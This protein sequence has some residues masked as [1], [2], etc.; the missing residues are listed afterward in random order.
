MIVLYILGGYI[1]IC[2]LWMFVICPIYFHIHRDE[3]MGSG[4]IGFWLLP[5]FPIIMLV[6]QISGII[7]QYF[8]KHQPFFMSGQY[9]C[10]KCSVKLTKD[11]EP[12]E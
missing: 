12:I 5:A 6:A 2:L 8:C 11:G 7:K 1:G 9:F 4:A 3:Y 10:R